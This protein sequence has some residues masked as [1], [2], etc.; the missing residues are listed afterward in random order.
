MYGTVNAA[1]L[2]YVPLKEYVSYGPFMAQLYA[3]Q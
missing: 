1:S 2:R 3:A